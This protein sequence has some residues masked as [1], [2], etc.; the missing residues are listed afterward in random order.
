MDLHLGLSEIGPEP[1]PSRRIPSHRKARALNFH[2]KRDTTD[3]ADHLQIELLAD[4]PEA[5]PVL[6][7]WFECEWAP[8]GLVALSGDEVC[9]TAALKKESVNSSSP[10]RNRPITPSS[11]LGAQEVGMPHTNTAV[12][13]AG[14]WLAVASLLMVAAFGF[15]GPLPGAEP[16]MSSRG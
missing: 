10:H 2:T 3:M 15:H 13:V 1:G 8:F 7:S 11:R 9:G 5:I 14:T 4:H 6:K 16:T 12:R